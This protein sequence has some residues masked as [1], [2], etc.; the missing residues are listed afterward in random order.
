MVVKTKEHSKAVL[1]V[2]SLSGEELA[3][4][5]KVRHLGHIIRRDLSDDDDLQRQ[6]CKPYAE[7]NMLA[8]KF[9]MCT[10]HVKVAL[11]KASCSALYPGH[12]W[13]C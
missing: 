3:V 7:A 5:D 4:V 1:P 13:C 2:F 11:F 9:G 8:P 10:E 12:S 6:Y